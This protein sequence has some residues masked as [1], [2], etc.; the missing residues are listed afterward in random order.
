MKHIAAGHHTSSLKTHLAIVTITSQA[1]IQFYHALAYTQTV[2]IR[3][4]QR[5]FKIKQPILITVE[6]CLTTLLVH[7]ILTMVCILRILVLLKMLYGICM[8]L[9]KYFR[10]QLKKENFSFR[11]VAITQCNFSDQHVIIFVFVPLLARTRSDSLSIN[12]TL[13]IDHRWYPVTKK[14]LRSFLNLK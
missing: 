4:T 3:V 14:R 13:Y 2:N 11:D 6:G 10:A 1:R 7:K 12:R 9:N 5:L 8:L